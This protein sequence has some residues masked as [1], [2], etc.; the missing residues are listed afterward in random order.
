MASSAIVRRSVTTFR[1]YD[2]ISINTSLYTRHLHDLPA[3]I[4]TTCLTDMMGTLQLATIGAFGLTNRLQTIVR[5]AHITAR[6]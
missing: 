2:K 4:M 6:P 5:T 3:I 1:P